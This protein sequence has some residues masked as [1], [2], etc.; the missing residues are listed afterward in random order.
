M[1]WLSATSAAHSSHAAYRSG[2][3]SMMPTSWCRASSSGPQA[4]SPSAALEER[5]ES[6]SAAKGAIESGQIGDLES[7]DHHPDGTDRDI[8]SWV[9]PA[10]YMDGSHGE[11]GG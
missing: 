4:G 11:E 10:S 7:D 6:L 8:D 3:V 9:L 5:Y 2:R 1:V